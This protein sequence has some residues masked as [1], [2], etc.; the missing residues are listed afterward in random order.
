MG[1][2]IINVAVLIVYGA[3]L[4]DVLSHGQVTQGIIDSFGG[5]WNTSIK[6][7]AGQSA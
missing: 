4:A 7:V 2:K 1:V 3:M 5:M 6:T